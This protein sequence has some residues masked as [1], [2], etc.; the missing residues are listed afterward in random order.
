[1][2]QIMMNSVVTVDHFFQKIH[3]TKMMRKLMLFMN[4]LIKGW[5]KNERSIVKNV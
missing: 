3:T 1:M 5:M 2:I 4:Q